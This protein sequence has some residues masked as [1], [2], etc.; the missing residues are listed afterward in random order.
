MT[1]GIAPPFAGPWATPQNQLRVAQRAEELGYG[2]LWTLSR[3]L[4]P[5]GPDGEGEQDHFGQVFRQVCEPIVT[6]AYLASRTTRIRLGIS[7]VVAP[8][9]SPPVLA[10]QL[11]ALDRVSGG[12]LDVGAAQGWSPEEFLAAGVPFERRLGRTLEYVTVLREMWENEIAAFDGE[13]AHLPRVLVRP[14]PV[15]RTLPL[16]L[17]G[18]GDK[19]WRRAGRLGSGWVGPAFVTREEVARAAELVREGA[20]SA[21]KD[22][23]AARIVVRAAAFV[24]PGGQPGRQLFNG[25][26]EEIA[27]DLAEM[28]ELGATEVFA[29]FNFDYEVVGPHTDPAASMD[30]IEHALE[31][32]A[33]TSFASPAAA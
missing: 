31:V 22:P 23:D 1:I 20:E 16:L 15:Q 14:R 27:A 18:S 2:S 28:R 13:F 6:L 25:S 21:G 32:L 17:G 4:F 26:L 7:A 33:P 3:L 11:I 30:L 5:V 19:A 24:R 29:D 12:R 9:Y 8:F 10:K